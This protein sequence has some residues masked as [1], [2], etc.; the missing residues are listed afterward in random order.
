HPEVKAISLLPMFPHSLNTRP[1]IIDEKTSISIKVLSKNGAIISLDSHK[2]LNLKKNEEVEIIKS[3][4][5]L[6]L[7]HPANHDFYS[8]C[9][10]KL[11]WSLNISDK[12]L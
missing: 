1:L 10:M 9:R 3:K 8:A 11:G 2:Y 4:P 6:K 12:D 5:K 7:I